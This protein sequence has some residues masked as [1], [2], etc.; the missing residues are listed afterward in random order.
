[1][2]KYLNISWCLLLVLGFSSC[3]VEE[4]DI[5]DTPRNLGGYAVL[6]DNHISIFDTNEDLSIKFFT[7]EG[8]TAE[9][10]EIIQDG[11]VIGTATVSGETATFNTSILGEL[12]ADSYPVRIRTTYSNGSIS[13]D[14]FTVSVDHAV[15]LGDNPT[16]TTMDSL[17]TVELSYEVSTFGATVDDVTLSVK[18]GSEG[19]YKPT[20][21]DLSTEEGT[22]EVSE[23]D[24]EGLEIDLAVNDTL[25]YQFTATSGTLSDSAESYVAIVP[26]AFTT[27]N[28]ATLSSDLAS[29]QLNLA[30]GEVS[31]DGDESG[32]IA[33]LDPI[34]FEVIN[35]ADLSFVSVPSDYWDDADVLSARELYEAGDPVTSV[36][37]LSDGDVF[38]YKATR[39]VLDEEGV[40]TGETTIV[41]GVLRVGAVTTVTADGETVVSYDL[42]FQEGM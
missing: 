5:R 40:P 15:S 32:E 29:N 18:E 3:D 14:P 31:A 19:T 24:W 10:V 16:E 7:T 35:S 34:G 27:S 39:P 12:E 4:D 11:A 42:D 2:K 21:L 33:F 38:V 26:K 17:S 23:I 37:D 36:T 9:S 6:S 22:V 20:G 25:Y 13:E 8:V 30:T 1:M 41:Y 28:E